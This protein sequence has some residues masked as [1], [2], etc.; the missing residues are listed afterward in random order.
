[1]LAL[2][3]FPSSGL[4]AVPQLFIFVKC[5]LPQNT[6]VLLFYQFLRC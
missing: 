4:L 6:L 3:N 1:M 2:R 5:E